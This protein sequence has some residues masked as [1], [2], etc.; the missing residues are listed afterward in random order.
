MSTVEERI[1]QALNEEPK[2]LQPPNTAAM[3]VPQSTHLYHSSYSESPCTESVH[4][5]HKRVR[6]TSGKWSGGKHGMVQQTK[7]VDN[8]SCLVRQLRLGSSSVAHQQTENAVG[9]RTH[10]EKQS[11]ARVRHMQ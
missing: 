9:H 2:K 11:N 5:L 10:T 4:E 1:P 3:G 8:Y 6:D 7:H